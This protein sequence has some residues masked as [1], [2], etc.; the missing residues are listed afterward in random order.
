MAIS[1]ISQLHV[2]G[3]SD[4]NSF[5][6]SVTAQTGDVI[7]LV[8]Q[9]RNVSGA[10][11]T[12][13]WNGQSFTALAARVDAAGFFF[14]RFYLVAA[15]S[16]TASITGGTSP[17]FTVLNR[18]WRVW[19][20]ST[21][22]FATPPFKAGSYQASNYLSGTYINPS[23][24][25]TLAANEVVSAVFASPNW[26][27][28]FGM[29][30]ATFSEVAPSVNIGEC[31]GTYRAEVEILRSFYTTGVGSV[32]SALT[33]TGSH[34]PIYQFSTVILQETSYLITSINGGSPITAGQTAIP[35]VA[36]GFTA[37]P[38]AVTA[39]YASGAKSITATVDSGGSATN[40]NISIQD[41]IEAEDWPINGDTLTFTFTYGSESASGNQTL[42][43]KST[44]TVLTFSGAI[45]SDQAYPTYWLTE[46][47]FTAEGGEL[48][49]IPY[50]GLVLTADGGGS[51][52]AAGEFDSWFRPATGTGA[53]NV[54]YYR[55]AVTEA[56]ITPSN[57]GMTSIG[58]TTAGLT[59]SGLTSAGL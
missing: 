24:T 46:D 17:S 40:F 42:V 37:K 26:D 36:S 1:I 33:K 25:N 30:T 15:S 19:R 14:H 52:P 28:G 57:R 11:F 20:S 12:P 43:K 8:L 48:A 9:Y 51:A 34:N 29:G 31:I 27:T 45:T 3:T 13:V 32:T 44:E 47:G 6:S 56:G 58:L 7:E 50:S 41:R 22:A 55:W 10:T 35:I 16:T 5:S 39:T 53:G 59:S 38:T 49:Y 21:N 2:A 23:I 54:Y 4:V 18:A